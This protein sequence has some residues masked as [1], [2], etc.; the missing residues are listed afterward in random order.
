MA[1][2]RRRSRAGLVP[3]GIRDAVNT[4]DAHQLESFD[5]RRR[6]TVLLELAAV[7]GVQCGMRLPHL[8][9]DIP[10]SHDGSSIRSAADSQRDQRV[11]VSPMP[12]CRW[13]LLPSL[14]SAS[15]ESRFLRHVPDDI[16][17]NNAVLLPLLGPQTFVK[18]VRA[19][20][21]AQRMLVL[22]AAHELGKTSSDRPF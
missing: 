8:G 20:V 3:I 11:S 13:G 7:G 21:A 6:N 9:S 18:S 5:R 12:A 19:R 17:A 14:S 2:D 16:E 1:A 22:S 4:S 15:R 10:G